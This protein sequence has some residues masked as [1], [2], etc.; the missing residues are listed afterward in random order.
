L[1]VDPPEAQIPQVVFFE[2]PELALNKCTSGEAVQVAAEPRA[3]L[4]WRI[5]DLYGEQQTKTKTASNTSPA[6]AT[7]RL[8]N[9]PDL[10]QLQA[11]QPGPGQDPEQCGLVGQAAT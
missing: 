5:V 1:G 11:E 3:F 4:V 2:T 7:A 10:D 6:S 9:P 8:G